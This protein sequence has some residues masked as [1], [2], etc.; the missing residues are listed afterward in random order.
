[1]ISMALGL[2]KKGFKIF[3]STF[4]AFLTRAHDQIRMAG[5]SGGNFTLCGSHAGVSVGEDG[6]SQMGLEDIALFRSTA[7]SS[8][9]CPCDAVSCEKIVYAC[10]ELKG[11]NYIRTMRPKTPI[12][13]RYDEL[14]DVGDFKILRQSPKDNLILAGSGITVHECLKAYEHLKKKGIASAVIDLYCVKPFNEK[15]FKEF[16][17][18]H[19]NKIIVSE[20]HYPQGGIGEMLSTKVVNDETKIISL[21]VRKMP[22]SGTTEELLHYEEID[23]ESIVKAALE[24]VKNS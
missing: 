7:N 10:K 14:F 17:K 15:K 22:R 8:I 12:I 23:A 2:S 3:S 19:G 4:A 13:Y 5:I 18:H 11:I 24:M 20:D 1:M 9:F 16:V 6:S 21:A